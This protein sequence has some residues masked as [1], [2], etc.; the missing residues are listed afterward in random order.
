MKIKI[1]EDEFWPYYIIISKQ[2]AGE[3]EYNIPP[4]IIEDYKLAQQAFAKAWK[5]LHDRVIAEDNK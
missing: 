5:K 4:K 1:I 2:T 3:S